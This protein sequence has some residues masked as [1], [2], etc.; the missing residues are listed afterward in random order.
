VRRAVMNRFRDPALRKQFDAMIRGYQTSHPDIIR[1]DGSKHRGNAAAFAFWIG[2]EGG[3]A[4]KLYPTASSR[5][6]IPYACF[7]AGQEATWL[8][9]PAGFS[10]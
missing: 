8:E 5:R 6:T 7:R 10:G 2:F 9:R 3:N 4:E 1:P